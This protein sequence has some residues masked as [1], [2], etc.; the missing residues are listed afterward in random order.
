MP[1]KRKNILQETI[2]EELAYDA[3]VKAVIIINEILSVLESKSGLN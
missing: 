1:S 2:L 3:Y